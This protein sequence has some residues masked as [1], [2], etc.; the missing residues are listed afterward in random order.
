MTAD[1]TEAQRRI[2]PHFNSGP[3]AIP[4]GNPHVRWLA[5]ELRNRKLSMEQVSVRAGL[6]R[7]I[8]SHWFRDRNPTLSNFEAV[9]NVLGYELR[10]VKKSE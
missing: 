2:T 6:A 1:L 10:I 8:I 4:N 9:L 3:K 5:Q 7:T